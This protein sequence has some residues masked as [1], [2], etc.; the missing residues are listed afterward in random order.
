MCVICSHAIA[1][2]DL[3]KAQRSRGSSQGEKA[4]II[5]LNGSLVLDHLKMTVEQCVKCFVRVDL[6]ELGHE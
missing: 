1:E 4:A 3:R 2:A 5:R 6:H